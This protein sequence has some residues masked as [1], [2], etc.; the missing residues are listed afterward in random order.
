MKKLFFFAF[1][2]IFIAGCDPTMLVSPI[3]TGVIIWKDGEA[4]K[5][6]NDDTSVI[7]RAT[8][9][10]LKELGYE[11]IKDEPTKD[12]YYIV[13]GKED[14]FKITIRKAKNHISEVKI[15]VNFMGDKP[16]AEL[17]YRQIDTNTNSIYYDE[18]GKPTRH[19]R[20]N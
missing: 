9:S 7:Y 15:R 12:G 14:R 20:R 2:S 8:K 11:I 19:M 13:A 6:Y 5:Y 18:Q 1:L 3:V 4:H 17:V 16:Y 10:S